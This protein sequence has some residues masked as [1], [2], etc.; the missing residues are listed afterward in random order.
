MSMHRLFVTSHILILVCINCTIRQGRV[1]SPL[2]VGFYLVVSIH[3]VLFYWDNRR[4]NHG[5]HVCLCMLLVLL[6]VAQA[7]D[8]SR[9]IHFIA[10]FPFSTVSLNTSLGL[11]GDP[12]TQEVAITPISLHSTMFLVSK[13]VMLS[14][15]AAWKK[16]IL[17]PDRLSS[18]FNELN[19]GKSLWGKAS[20]RFSPCCE[21]ITGRTPCIQQCT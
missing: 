20:V 16:G 8:V 15:W 5:Q 9:Y 2:T 3:V 6:S 19:I 4:G 18:S 13:T 1:Q 10:G 12:L 7:E 17:I 11:D 21:V 14:A